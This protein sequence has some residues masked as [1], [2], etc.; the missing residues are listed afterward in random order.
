MVYIVTK[1][2]TSGISDFHSMTVDQLHNKRKKLEEGMRD[3]IFTKDQMDMKD[4]K[5]EDQEN[6]RVESFC[7]C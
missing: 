7:V 5:D 2:K 6:K 1:S 3:G 4:C